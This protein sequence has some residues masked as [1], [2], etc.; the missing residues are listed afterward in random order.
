MLAAGGSSLAATAGGP[1]ALPVTF[2]DA[3][4][5][6]LAVMRVSGASDDRKIPWWYT[7][8]IYGM[9]P[10][11][12]PRKLV[13]FEGCEIYRFFAQPD[14][15]VAQT[16]RTTSFFQDIESGAVLE[17]WNNPYT[18]VTVDVRANLL[19]GSGG[20]VVWSDAGLDPQYRTPGGQPIP[21]GGPQPLRVTWT[22]Y[23]KWVWMRQDRVYPPGVP[24][25]IGECSA[26]LVERRDL[27]N[28][29]LKA[30]PALF[31]STYFAPWLGWMGMQGQPGH[32]IWHA[33]GVKLAGIDELP[34]AF[35]ER[36]RRLHPGQLEV[37]LS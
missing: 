18:G 32:T 19:G 4:T 15:T 35:L 29:R 16:A 25:P 36:I 8:Y 9:R 5:E 30:I 3:R 22:P 14:G 31:S 34:A 28:R 23:G 12:Q 7:G 13:R 17:R 37:S 1:A 26:M 33:D 24:P 21:S 2:T 20:R 11:E 10:G 27:Q 6:R